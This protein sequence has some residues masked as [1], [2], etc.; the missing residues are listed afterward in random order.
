MN[1]IGKTP[2]LPIISGT[3]SVRSD[4]GRPR[5]SNELFSSFE[6]ELR[7]DGA[8]G[9]G[10]GEGPVSGGYGAEKPSAVEAEG[11]TGNSA[12]PPP[13][14]PGFAVARKLAGDGKSD[15]A[16]GRLLVDLDDINAAPPEIDGPQVPAPPVGPFAYSNRTD[17]RF[18]YAASAYE[19][20][21]QTLKSAD[22]LRPGVI[23]SERF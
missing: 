10:A 14:D 7:D 3:G 16:L 18:H 17:G 1:Q 4:S 13:D 6:Q 22:P 20:G 11:A 15:E 8:H 19:S 5:N 2:V 9:Q 21:A 23:Y 12:K